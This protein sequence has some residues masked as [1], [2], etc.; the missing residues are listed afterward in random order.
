MKAELQIQR[1]EDLLEW[2]EVNADGYTAKQS[3]D[4]LIDSMGTLCSYMAFVNGQ[5]TVAKKALNT[6][7]VQ[8]Y[9]A[10]VMS[11]K[12]QEKY[13]SPMLAKDYVAA[14]CHEAQYNYD[15]CE[16]ASRTIVHTIEALRTCISALK[17]EAKIVSYSGQV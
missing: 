14:K 11:S 8:A 12:A 15:V 6:Q 3:I 17:E 9:N 2:M 13:F 7:K 5:M 16:R 1:V 4:W 10:L